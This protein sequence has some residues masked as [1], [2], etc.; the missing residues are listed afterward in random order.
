MERTF[1]APAQAVFDAWTSEEVMRRW[2]HAE[3]DWETT[4]A[5]VDL[6][7]GG[8]VRVVMRNPHDDIEYGGGGRY[9][10]IEPPTRLAFTWIW[11]GDTKRQLIELDF[12]EA[13]GVTT[14]RFTHSGLWDEESVRSH[15]DGWGKAF[16]NLERALAAA[17]SGGWTASPWGWGRPASPASLRRLYAGRLYRAHVAGSRT[18]GDDAARARAWMHGSHAVVCDVVAPWEHGT[19]V[20]ATRYPTYFDF[21]LVRVEDD[22][23]LSVDELLSFADEALAGLT[24]RHLIF[25]VAAAGEPL[26]AG[27]VE[28]GWKATR[29][30]WMRRAGT[31]PPGAGLPVEWVPY[32]AVHE[33]RV[34]WLQEE[35]PNLD[36][37]DHHA[38]ARELAMRTNAEVFAAVENGAPV[39]FAQLVRDGEGAEITDVYVTA[40][41]RGR[42]LGTAIT[43]AAISAAGD[44]GELW[45][46]ADA[47]DR[48]KE[49]YARLGFRP[50][51]TVVDYLRLQH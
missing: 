18:E 27:F 44:V 49:L 47:D 2:W 40:R 32:D 8:A 14:V 42:G 41:R 20:R 23:E 9:T 50:A 46:I 7:V 25:E 36:M 6:R 37:T 15:E 29:L 31:P 24:H 4:E 33:L 30:V 38:E 34:A 28:L 12:E 3:H 11:D 22:A 1:H 35:F 10:E 16:D 5:E 17:R 51:W 48:P 39:A 13:D 21:N 26:R 19:V 43:R 45:I